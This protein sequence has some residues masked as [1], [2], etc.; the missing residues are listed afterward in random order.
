LVDEGRNRHAC[1]RPKIISAE[2]KNPFNPKK[3]SIDKGSYKPFFE[4]AGFERWLYFFL[5]EGKGSVNMEVL[6]KFDFFW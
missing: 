4:M 1:S 2:I 5:N 6:A 3:F